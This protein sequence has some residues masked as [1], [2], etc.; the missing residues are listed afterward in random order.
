MKD[1]L[2]FSLGAI[3]SAAFGI[4]ITYLAVGWVGKDI[5]LWGCAV[6]IFF[7]VVIGVRH[8]VIEGIILTAVFAGGGYFVLKKIPVLLPI[9]P[10]AFA[11]FSIFMIVM[12]LIAEAREAPQREAQ[13]RAWKEQEEQN[14]AKWKA[15]READKAEWEIYRRKVAELPIP[16]PKADIGER[17]HAFRTYLN[18]VWHRLPPQLFET[19]DEN[20]ELIYTWLQRQFVKIVG[21]P[22]GCRLEMQYGNYDDD[23]DE[24]LPGAESVEP[25]A[26][27]YQPMEIWVNETYMFDMLVGAHDGWYDNK[28]PFNYISVYEEP[29]PGGSSERIYIPFDQ[30]RIELRPASWIPTG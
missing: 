10:G 21:K 6:L 2:L 3:I 22:L 12:G 24:D 7:G 5:A 13:E 30:A 29:G 20:Y 26:P 11:G 23:F 25:T 28:P 14:E 4:V 1:I 19:N 15:K 17:L 9:F 18:K 27:E 8:T 16:T